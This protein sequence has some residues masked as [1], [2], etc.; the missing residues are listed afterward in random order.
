MLIILLLKKIIIKLKIQLR[1]KKIHINIIT[2]KILSV[3]II[4]LFFQLLIITHLFSKNSKEIISNLFFSPQMLA[5]SGM[6]SEY[7]RKEMPSFLIQDEKLVFK[8]YGLGVYAGKAIMSVTHNNKTNNTILTH[9]TAYLSKNNNHFTT[10]NLKAYTGAFAS[11][12]YKLDINLKSY[13]H[14]YT[15][16]T[17]GYMENKIEKQ[18]ISKHK[19]LIYPELLKN[20]YYLKLE[21]T[22]PDKIVNV[23]KNGFDLV[24]SLFLARCLELQKYKSFEFRTFFREREY[25]TEIIYKGKKTIKYKKQKIETLIISPRLKYKGLFDNRGELLIYLENNENRLPL[26]METKLSI[27]KIYAKLNS[28]KTNSKLQ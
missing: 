15:L 7:F 4:G 22:N 5:H 25:N 26:L 8:V 9:N 6:K 17:I 21:S 12:F 23:E 24:S 18:K 14:P 28:V 11:L 19:L 3:F 10:F 27:G 2:M 1:N 16:Y 13:A 20:E